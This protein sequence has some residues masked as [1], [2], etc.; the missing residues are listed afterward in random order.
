MDIIQQL[1]TLPRRKKLAAV[2]FCAVV[3]FCGI[4]IAGI[5]SLFAGG[6][7]ADPT[8]M[9][10]DPTQ[11]QTTPTQAESVSTEATLDSTCATEDTEE[12][13]PPVTQEEDPQSS[14][15]GHM[16][17]DNGA[18]VD[19]E[20]AITKNPNE[21]GD[22]TFG[23][24]V[25]RYQGTI[26]WAKVA[27]S[28]IDFVMVRV[29]YRELISGK[30]VADSNAKY[31]MQ[32]A[33]KH[34]I[35]LGAY[36]FST[37]VTKA[38]AEEEANW[39]ADYISRYS[40]TY[41]VAYNCEGFGD[42]ESRQYSLTKSERT[43]LALAFLERIS[44]RGYTPMFYAS[45]NEMEGDAQWEIS[46]VA[47][48]Y[49]VW[50]AQ[51]PAQP[52]PQTES[53]SYT[54]QHAM[55]QYTNN[56]T[57]PGISQKVDVNIAYFGYTQAEDPKNDEDPEQAGVD[58]EAL[59]NFREVSETVTAKIEAN[60]RDIPDQGENSKVLY[61]LK[62]GQTA[63]RTGI[64]DSG[65]SR[66]VFDGKTCYAVSSLLTTDLTYTDTPDETQPAEMQ[67]T[68]V[69]EQVTAKIQTNLRDV[70]SQGEDSTVMYTL[71]NGEVATRTG[72]NENTG[73]SR[74][75]WNGNTYYAVSSYLTTDLGYE[76]PVQINTPFTQ[77]SEQVTAKDAVNLRTLPSVTDPN[78]QV[79]AQI[80]NGEVVTRT[81]I[82]EDVGWSR[83][84]YNGQTLYCVSSYLMLWTEE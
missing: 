10:T 77:V 78:S 15:G 1:K 18:S 66:V 25:S 49:K 76:P 29:G 19:V 75:E 27:D 73:W 70:P 23:I 2:G 30:I 57:V 46:R 9:L 7:D 43:D 50:V 53:S 72:I 52:Y 83:V 32:E 69:S 20:S 61:T 63:T 82:N 55:W 17:G 81:G 26:D 39:V 80:K 22:I 13:T 38:E 62:N 21:T 65:W 45:R 42:S 33:Q 40:I 51:Y 12:T 36:F 79:V 24:D 31:N 44:Q 58:V 67:F 48:K 47:P 84:E 71:K 37:A 16:S 8:T 11:V 74:V 35:K 3:V 59:M 4:V 5:I 60:L 68:Q 41:P 6:A 14:S 28:G 34:G 54:G 64:S 56:G